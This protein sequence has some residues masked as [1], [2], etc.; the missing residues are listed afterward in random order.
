VILVA[1]KGK[2]TF[3]SSNEHNGI[4]EKPLFWYGQVVYR[5][6]VLKMVFAKIL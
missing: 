4:D 2:Y 5:W 3:E 1:L 6:Q